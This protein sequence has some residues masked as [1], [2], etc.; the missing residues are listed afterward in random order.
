MAVL[1]RSISRDFFS[2]A[3]IAELTPLARL[4]Y[5]ATWLEAD[6]EGRLVWHPKT[7]KLRY[8]ALDV[9]DINVIANE[10]IRAAIVIPYQASGQNLA[11]L[12]GFNGMQSIN[13]REAQS[14]LPPPPAYAMPTRGDV[15]P[16]RYDAIPT[17]VD[18]H[19]VMEC[20]GV[21][22]NGDP[23]QD[24]GFYPPPFIQSD[25]GANAENLAGQEDAT[26]D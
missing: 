19:G 2:N 14:K 17:R 24:R 8:L 7:L 4:L 20:N 1:Y 21:K 12:P 11:F 25:I 22:C 23:S 9:C 18:V 26:W 15:S 5:I 13:G 16:S 3:D 10:L 6:R